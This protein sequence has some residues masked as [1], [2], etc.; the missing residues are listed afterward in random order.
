MSA[1]MNSRR[2]L[3][4]V[5]LA[6]SAGSLPSP[7]LAIGQQAASEPLLPLWRAVRAAWAVC[8]ESDDESDDDNEAVVAA[9]RA[10]H[11]A[12]RKV[13]PTST[14]GLFL[15]LLDTDDGDNF[16]DDH[17]EAIEA[18]LA[19]LEAANVPLHSLEGGAA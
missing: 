16:A 12:F 2:S 8:A 7:A 14:L 9:Y 1:R 10:A 6:A 13:E 19:Q 11:D 3:L 4:G 17:P 5:A 15:T 18:M